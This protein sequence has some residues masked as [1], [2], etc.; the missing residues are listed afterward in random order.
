GDQVMSCGEILT[1]RFE[2]PKRG[3]DRVVLRRSSG[4]REIVWEHS[5]VHK[6][7]ESEKDLTRD[8]R[9]AASQRKAR[10]GDHRVATPIAEPV[11]A[12]NDG[13]CRALGRALGGALG[14]ALIGQLALDDK[15]IRR[16]QELGEPRGS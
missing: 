10:Q 9:A 3:V 11:I 12:S 2:I 16:E 8:V 15:L 14:R 4:V 13:L 1:D 7:G 6:T 5:P